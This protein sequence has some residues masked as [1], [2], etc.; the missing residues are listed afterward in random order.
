MWS[1]TNY[2]LVNL[3]LADLMMATLNCVPSFLYMRDRAW[4]FGSLYC[5]LNQFISL[6]TVPASVFTMLAITLERRR[7]IM[8]PLSPRAN[9]Q[10]PGQHN[11]KIPF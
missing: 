5:C 6:T 8:Q 7:A 3:T 1:V 9:K 10:V 2:F 11:V 4:Y